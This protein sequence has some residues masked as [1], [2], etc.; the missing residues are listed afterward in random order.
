MR[1][2]LL[3]LQKLMMWLPIILRL[4]PK[5]LA[6][7][8]VLWT[9]FSTI[10]KEGFKAALIGLST[11]I[12]AAEKII[13]DKTLLAV[14]TPELYGFQD[15]IAILSSLFLIFFVALFIGKYLLEW[16]TGSQAKLS[17]FLMGLLLVFLIEI[18]VIAL[19]NHEFFFPFKDGILILIKNWNSVI[20]IF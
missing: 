4:I 19:T 8:F 10:L 1:G 5:G 9:F 14:N 6:G 11:T 20:Q 3:I 13:R 15:L 16:I 7:I 17:A 18:V 2:I 12:F